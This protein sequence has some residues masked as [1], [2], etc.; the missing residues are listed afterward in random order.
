MNVCLGVLARLERVSPT[1]CPEEWFWE[2]EDGKCLQFE[3]LTTKERRERKKQ[4]GWN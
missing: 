4:L 2:E 3:K 1:D